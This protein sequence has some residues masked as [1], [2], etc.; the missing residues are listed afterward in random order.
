MPQNTDSTAQRRRRHDALQTCTLTTLYHLAAAG[1]VL[2]VIL[3][4]SL[5]GFWC[6]VAWLS[7]LLDLGTLIPVW[8]IYKQR[9]K[10]IQGGEEDAAA[11]Y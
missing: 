2:W 8:I 4:Y 9:I 10:E 5:S 3:H 6:A 7:I 1:I 11:Q